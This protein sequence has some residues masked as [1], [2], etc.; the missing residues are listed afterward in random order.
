MQLLSDARCRLEQRSAGVRSCSPAPG[1]S[2]RLTH[3][4]L[5]VLPQKKNSKQKRRP[6]Y[7]TWRK[8]FYFFILNMKTPKARITRIQNGQKC[9]SNGGGEEAYLYS[10][11]RL[12]K[13]VTDAC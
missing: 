8:Q 1:S 5:Q 4:V 7:H 11:F 12:K 6:L 13:G 3:G 2:K 9:K 10:F